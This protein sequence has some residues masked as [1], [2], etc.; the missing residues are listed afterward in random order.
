[1][2]R[3][4]RVV[5]SSPSIL[6]E[7]GK[8]GRV[9]TAIAMRSSMTS[10]VPVAVFASVFSFIYHSLKPQLAYPSSGEPSCNLPQD[11]L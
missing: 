10:P 1:M 5:E 9:H 8:Y 4:D 6:I 3:N 7:V 2:R 11:H